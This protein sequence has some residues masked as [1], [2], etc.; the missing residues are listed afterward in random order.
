MFAINSGL[1]VT[2]ITTV[3]GNVDEGLVYDNARWI[4]D[5][6]NPASAI[7]LCR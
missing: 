5:F 2:T 7:R 6:M 1:D 4:L 3:S